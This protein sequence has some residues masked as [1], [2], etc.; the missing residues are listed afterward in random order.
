MRPWRALLELGRALR[1]APV[2]GGTAGLHVSES[3]APANVT[4]SA[5]SNDPANP[6][7]NLNL[8]GAGTGTV[9]VD[10]LPIGTG[11]GG[12]G[13]FDLD[14]GDSTSSYGSDPFDLDEGG[15]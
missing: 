11:G 12:G 9:L 2:L 8:T 5:F 14:G 7:V 10:G 13:S 3:V 4:I 15:S 1:L 6:N